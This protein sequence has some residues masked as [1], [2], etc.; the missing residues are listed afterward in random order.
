ML[1]HFIITIGDVNGEWSVLEDYFSDEMKGRLDF[2]FRRLANRVICAWGGAF[3]KLYGDLM[4]FR[5]HVPGHVY[6]SARK[7]RESGERKG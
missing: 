1:A 4:T 7:H 6:K 3:E 2:R 5:S